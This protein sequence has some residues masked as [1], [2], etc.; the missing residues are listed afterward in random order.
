M[1]SQFFMVLFMGQKKKCSSDWLWHAHFS[2]PAL[3]I[4]LTKVR[5]K[6]LKR[7]ETE[8]HYLALVHH[9]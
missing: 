4:V 5:T 7:R 9:L 2:I 1:Q 8:I 3:Q 6:N